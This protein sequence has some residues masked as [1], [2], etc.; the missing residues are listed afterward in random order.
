MSREDVAAYLLMVIAWDGV[1]GEKGV[2][3]DAI[4]RWRRKPRLA[5]VDAYL[6]ALA[7]RRGVPIFSK[8][9]RELEAEGVPVTDP[10][11]AGR[12]NGLPNPF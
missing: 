2:M 3:V 6:A 10:L 4:Q 12:D 7:T 11:P 1:R 9:V 5:F 8:N